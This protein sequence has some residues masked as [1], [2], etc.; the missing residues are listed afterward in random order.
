MATTCQ[1]HSRFAYYRSFLPWIVATAFTVSGIIHLVHPTTF[2][3]IVPHFLPLKTEFVYIS[4]V[5]ELICAV[6][7]WCRQR[8]AGIAAAVLLILIWPA[9]LQAAIAA[10]QGHDESDRFFDW[11]R[12]PLQVPLIW[13]ALQS[14]RERT[15]VA[16]PT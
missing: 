3:S 15:R 1:S 11:V 16:P 2:T 13:F 9:N 7:L 6:G 14:G 5:A 8:W 12:L 4:G 10:Q